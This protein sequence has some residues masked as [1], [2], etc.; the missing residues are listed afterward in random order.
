MKRLRKLAKWTLVLATL[1]LATL[2]VAIS[3]DTPCG[4]APP[5]AGGDTMQ[6]V[7]HRCYGPP[8][9]LEIANIAR[10]VPADGEVLVKVRAA[11]INPYEWHYMRG[12]PY[13]MRLEAGIGTPKS[14]RLGVDFSGVVEAVGPGVTR[15]VPGDAVFGGKGGALAE[16]IVVRADRTIAKK[17]DHVSFEQAA[18]VQIAALTA[19][20]AVRDRGAVGAGDKVLVNGAS[21]GV[22][23]FAVQIAKAYGAEV[24]G[25][26]SARNAELV[27]SLG[28]DRVIDY[29]AQDYT[30]EDVKYDV[31]IDMVGSR[32]LLDNR[33]VLKPDGRL[34]II[35]GPDGKWLG[36][37]AAPLR[38]VL[39]KPFVSQEMG[40]MLSHANAPDLEVLR[41]LLAAGRIVPVVDRTF[42]L[43]QIREA[44]TYLETGRARGKVVVTF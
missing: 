4:P 29:N 17:P 2:A 12:T 28:A 9:V 43:A 42:P 10:P 7:V 36:P 25:V 15:F 6:A 1:A 40:M 14:D 32:G 21:G 24:T 38:A 33:R 30:A 19:L 5:A 39:L 8:D 23:T 27:R 16:Y 3:W 22:G 11:G 44:M 18:G 41:E 20:Q 13:L 35:G 26:C 37:L 31:I 34:V